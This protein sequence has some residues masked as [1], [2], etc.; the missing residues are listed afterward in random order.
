MAE[1]FI[2]GL[3]DH[4]Q[5]GD[6]WPLASVASFFVSRIDGVIDKKID[7]HAAAG[8]DDART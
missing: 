3:E 4:K 5:G 1:A 8:G 6:D 7:E 2:A